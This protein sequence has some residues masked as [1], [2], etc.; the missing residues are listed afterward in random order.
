MDYQLA[1]DDLAPDDETVLV[2]ALEVVKGSDVDK[3]GRR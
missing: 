3:R 1:P 2:V